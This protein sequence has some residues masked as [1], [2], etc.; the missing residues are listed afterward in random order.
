MKSQ[1]RSRDSRLMELQVESDQL[2]EQSARQ[3]AVI[4]SLKKRIKEMEDRERELYAKQGHTDIAMQT[5]HRDVRYHE[6][7][8]KDLEVKLRNMELEC[9]SEVQKKEAARN[10]LH[11]LVRRL[12]VVLGVDCCDAAHLTPDSLILKATEIVQVN[13]LSPA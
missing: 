12:A 8:A 5:M 7:R 2:R 1:L 10:A 4:D 6:D 3:S 11:D 13:I 9:N